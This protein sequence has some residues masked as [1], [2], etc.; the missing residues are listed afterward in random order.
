MMLLY[1]KLLGAGWL[2][3]VLFSPRLPLFCGEMAQLQENINGIITAFY[4]YARSDGDCSTLSRGE[5]RQLIEQEFEDVIVDARDPRTVEK[6]LLFL[7][8]DSSGKVDFG[9]FLSLV[10]RVAKACHRQF[11]QYLEPEDDQEL[12]VQEEADGEQHHNQVQEQGVSEEVQ[13]SGTTQQHQ[14]GEEEKNHQDTQQKQEGE[15]PKNQD[16]QNIEKT[17]TPKVQDTQQTQEVETPNNQGTQEKKIEIPKDIQ[18]THQDDRATAPEEGPKR[19]ENVVTETPE[20]DRNTPEAEKTPKHDPKLHQD[21]VTETPELGQNNHHREEL[22]P[23]EQSHTSPTVTPGRTTDTNKN[24]SPKETQELPPPVRGTDP[25]PDPQPSGTRRDP[26]HP[27]DL[28][29]TVREGSV[30]EAERVPGHQQHGAHGKGKHVVEKENL[31]PQRPP[32]K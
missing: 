3:T 19:G 2:R 12:T 6:V 17:E 14:E 13:E 15:T 24:P 8:E 29:V 1:I 10:F 23:A 18:D 11:Q 26:A 9:E 32:R 4:T 31:Q 16:T 28:T 20:K 30:A 22:E 25:H 27:P 7:D 21:K 5:L